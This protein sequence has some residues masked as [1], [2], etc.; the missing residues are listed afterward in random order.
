MREGITKGI[1]EHSAIV[2]SYAIMDQR[3]HET[4]EKLENMNIDRDYVLGWIGGYMHNPHREEQ[5]VT[6][7]YS[8][9]Y[10]DGEKQET[11]HAGDWKAK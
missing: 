8:A 6:E 10:S 11:T 4:I 2:R 7:A 1:I 5:R 3:Y 9:G